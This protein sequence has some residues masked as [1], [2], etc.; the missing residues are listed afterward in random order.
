MKIIVVILLCGIVSCAKV[1]SQKIVCR[2]SP[3]EVAK[4]FPEYASEFVVKDQGEHVM[5][6]DS[7]KHFQFHG[8]DGEAFFTFLFDKLTMFRWVYGNGHIEYAPL[9]ASDE[10]EVEKVISGLK[11]EYGTGKPEGRNGMDWEMPSGIAG[12]SL[13]PRDFRFQVSDSMMLGMVT[14]PHKR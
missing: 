5:K 1:P 8:V 4:V 13:L 3:S 12:Y 14:P 11:E 2:M 7:I 10:E 6:V 9:S